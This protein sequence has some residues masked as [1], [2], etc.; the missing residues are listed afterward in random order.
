MEPDKSESCI[1]PAREYMRRIKL[2]TVYEEIGGL[3]YS[4][5]DFESRLQDSVIMGAQVREVF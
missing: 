4:V 5:R 2:E 3:T 1:I